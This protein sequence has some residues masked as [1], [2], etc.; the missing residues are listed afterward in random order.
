MVR[1]HCTWLQVASRISEHCILA[2]EVARHSRRLPSVSA[3]G[4]KADTRPEHERAFCAFVEGP[5][6]TLALRGC[7]D[8]RRRHRKIA[9]L[10]LHLISD[11]TAGLA[12]PLFFVA[13]SLLPCGVDGRVCVLE[14]WFAACSWRTWPRAFSAVGWNASHVVRRNVMVRWLH[15]LGIHFL[16]SWGWRSL[17]NDTRRR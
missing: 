12:G 3:C 15:S 4:G 11:R 16:P 17:L 6:R 2:P 13:A 5:L 7:G 9:R 14:S 10:K 1:P 8:Y